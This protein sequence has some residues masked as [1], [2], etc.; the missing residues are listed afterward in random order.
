MSDPNPANH[1][2]RDPLHGPCSLIVFSESFEI[3]NTSQWPTDT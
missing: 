3:D 1:G 2:Y